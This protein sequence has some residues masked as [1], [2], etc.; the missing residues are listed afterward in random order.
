MNKTKKNCI[1]ALLGLFVL[2]MTAA[3][4][5]ADENDEPGILD[6]L[7][8]DPDAFAENM[9]D[10][11]TSTDD[12]PNLI[13]PGPDSDEEP[14]L[15]SPNPNADKEPLIIAPGNTMEKEDVLSGE[16]NLTTGLIL[17]I[18]ISGIAGLAIALIIFKK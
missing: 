1:F 9:I 11:S 15:I 13:A 16:N 3:S 14:N 5:S 6:R 18:G 2:M 17:V 8:V 7:D 10:D 4:V 12:E